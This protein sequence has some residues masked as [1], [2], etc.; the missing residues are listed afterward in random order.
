MTVFCFLLLLDA[1]KREIGDVVFL[2][3]FAANTKQFF[4]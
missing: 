4:K 2:V 1:T 3:F